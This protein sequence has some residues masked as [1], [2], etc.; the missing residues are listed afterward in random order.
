[1]YDVKVPVL[2]HLEKLNEDKKVFFLF[3][4]SD[5]HTLLILTPR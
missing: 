1:M 5:R 3:L 2:D 4:V